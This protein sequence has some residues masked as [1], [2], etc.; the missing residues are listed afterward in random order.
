LKSGKRNTKCWREKI[1]GFGEERSWENFAFGLELRRKNQYCVELAREGIEKLG[2]RE[3]C[4]LVFTRGGA[5]VGVYYCTLPY[6]W[7]STF[8]QL[9][10]F[11]PRAGSNPIKILAVSSGNQVMA[12]TGFDG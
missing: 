3:F 11:T 9:R 4:F 6:G 7:N 5:G 2:A 10:V 12:C 8:A 1:G